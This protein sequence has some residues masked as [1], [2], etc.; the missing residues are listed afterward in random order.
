MGR[1]LHKQ[2]RQLCIWRLKNC[3]KSVNNRILKTKREPT[4]LE[5]S[6]LGFIE[7]LFTSASA[8]VM[9]VSKLPLDACSIRACSISKLRHGSIVNSPAA[10]CFTVFSQTPC[11]PS[12]FQTSTI[13][14]DTGLLLKAKMSIRDLTT[15]LESRSSHGP[16]GYSRLNVTK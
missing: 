11:R 15:E 10:V 7:Y 1:T 4:V 6:R 9:Y 16:F 5:N 3:L 12:F 13:A 2:T 14:L 8:L